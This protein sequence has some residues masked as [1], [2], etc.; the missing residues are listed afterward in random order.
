MGAE[1]KKE[2][3]AVSRAEELSLAKVVDRTAPKHLPFSAVCKLR[4][5]R[6]SLGLTLKDVSEAAGLATSVVCKIELGNETTLSSA[7][8]LARFYG[9]IIEELWIIPTEEKK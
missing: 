5:L 1:P 3:K 9:K 6:L 4:Q 7:F 8:K 2:G